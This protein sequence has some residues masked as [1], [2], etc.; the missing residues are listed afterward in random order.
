MHKRYN[1][2]VAQGSPQPKKPQDVHL[3]LNKVRKDVYQNKEKLIIC[4]LCVMVI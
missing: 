1:H 4:Y 2:K 3:N